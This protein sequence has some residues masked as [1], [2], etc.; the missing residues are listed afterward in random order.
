MTRARY[1]PRNFRKQVVE[2]CRYVR[3]LGVRD[4]VNTVMNLQ[5][6]YKM[7]DFSIV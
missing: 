6:T 5:V 1:E 2:S 4:F 3:L 7:G